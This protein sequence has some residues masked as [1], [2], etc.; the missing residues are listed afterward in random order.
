MLSREPKADAPRCAI[1]SITGAIWDVWHVPMCPTCH[2]AW[3]Q[4]DRFTAGAI[5]DALGLSNSPEE[6]TVAGHARYC[7]E[8]EK[9]TRAWVAELRKARAA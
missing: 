1:C 4:D 3:L 9:R 7:A 2:G 6:F 5:N 8:A